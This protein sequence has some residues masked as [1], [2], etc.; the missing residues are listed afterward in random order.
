[1]PQIRTLISESSTEWVYRITDPDV[2]GWE[3]ILNQPKPTPEETNAQ[4]LRDRA[5]TALTANATFLAI[6]SPTNA[7][8]LA[9]TRMLTRECTALIRL[10]L[11]LLDSTDGT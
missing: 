1:M 8:V 3:Y 5:Q 2:P 10:A 4:T 11:N 9:Q 6:A 7:Q